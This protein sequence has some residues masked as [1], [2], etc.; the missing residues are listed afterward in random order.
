[1]PDSQ[2]SQAKI[3]VVDDETGMREGCRRALS[4]AGYNVETADSLG[5]ALELIQDNDYDLYLLDVMLPDGSGLDLMESILGQDPLAVCIII[6]GF[7]SIEMAANAVKRGA[8]YFLAK[9]FTSD[10]LTVSVA[11]GLE[12]KRLKQVELQARE[13]ARAKEELERLDEAKSRLMLT[14]AHE[15]RA[16]VAAVR[17][18]VNL[19]L[20]DYMSE[21]EI[22]PTL[23]RIQELLQEVLDLTVD[24]LELANLKQA[25]GELS[26][27][28]TSQDAAQVLS[29]V[30]D[31]LQEQA[32]DKRQTF[33]VEIVDRPR[34]TAHREHL[35][36]IWRNL[37]S[38][39]IKYTQPG[40]NI[41][42]RLEV[43]GAD[44][45]STVQDSGIGV[46]KEDLD[47]LFQE[48]YRTDQAKASGEIGTG[49]GLSIAKQI[50]NSYGGDIWVNSDLGQGSTFTFR[51]PLT[52]L[53]RQDTEPAQP[54]VGP[55]NQSTQPSN[56]GQKRPP[57][58][59][60]GRES[61]N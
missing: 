53:P 14:V 45:L 21:E 24:L 7:G 35:K 25:K 5:A 8:Y 49:L 28:A 15:L 50:L 47:N 9:P 42:V 57:R 32:R 10:E 58:F 26:V 44:L 56:E 61:L 11:Q 33:Q 12:Q 4:P 43:D 60:L 41:S 2:D 23:S 40:G 20:A 55:E 39:A 59:V 17:S 48:F 37:I 13:L 3:L 38:N 30:V 34:V 51:L 19:L 52:Q 31:L 36:Q 27:G 46:A 1:V 6:T 16:P 54:P 22:K 29:E 18:Y